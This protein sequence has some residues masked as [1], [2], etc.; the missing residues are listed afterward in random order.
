VRTLQPDLVG[1]DAEIEAIEAFLA[2]GEGDAP[3]ALV[4][5]GEAGIGKTM[6]WR[7][8]VAL[9]DALSYRVLV[10]RPTAA[11]AEMP[12]AGLN[13]LLGEA[14]SEIGQRLPSPQRHALEVA[15][16]V[17][18]PD[19]TPQLPHTIAAAVLTSLRELAGADPIL[20]AIDDAQWLDSSS[21]AALD[22][23]LRRTGEGGRVRFLLSW[24]TDAEGRSPLGADGPV[25]RVPVGPLS[26]G[27][28][29]RV[30][31]AHLG[32][33]L[34]RPVLTRV[35]VA[36]RG[37]PFFALEL[38]RV[39]E[40]RGG[41]AAALELPLP[42]SLAETLRARLDAVP[43]DTRDT[44]LTVA[45]VSTPRLELLEAVLGP[46]ANARLQP[47]IDS[48]M[49]VVD[50]GRIRFSHPLIAAA[51]YA[52]AWPERRR[53]CHL[54]LAKLVGDEDERARHLALGSQGTNAELASALEDAAHRARLRGA[55]EA[56]AALGEQAWKATPAEEPDDAWR[57]G[58]LASEYHLQSGDVVRFGE[59][60]EQLLAIARTGDER[61]LACL[62]LSLAMQETE[63]VNFWL[64]RAL[65]EAEST[66]QR[67]SVESDYVTVATVGGDLAAGT[68]H[69]RES[70]RLAEE[71]DDPAVLADAISNVARHEQLL[72]LGLRRD[73]LER[74][75]S[76]HQL[77]ET[78]RLEETVG[79]IRTTIAS[80]GLL[81]TADEFAEARARSGALQEILEQ[82]GLVQ[83]LPEVLRFRAELECWAGDWDLAGD[84]AEAGNELAEQT[85]RVATRG[86]LLF[87]RAFVAAHRGDHEVARALASEGVTAAEESSNHRNLLRH[88]SVLG[89]LD[90][91]LDDRVGAAA[92][93][94]RAAQVATAAGYVEPNWLRFHDDLTEVLIGLGRL[95][96]AAALVTWL[97]ERSLATSYPWT[98]ATTA[99][100]RGQLLMARDDLDAA[101][102]ALTEALRIGERLGNPFELAR[103][104]L[105][106][107]R[108]YRRSRQRTQAG[109]ALDE[110]LLR[111]EQLGAKLWAETTRREL[112]RISGRRVGDAD[113]LTE[114]ERRIA[115][116]VAQGRPNKEVAAALH[117]SVKT[118]EVT[119]TR[120]YRKLGVRSRG[121]LAA[122]FAGESII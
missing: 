71:L 75:D 9:A 14:L 118:V 2:D 90:L 117:L 27:A 94:E 10:A 45:A 72:G 49:L 63:A 3:S 89:F 105:D 115:E 122:R 32:H 53:A 57:R 16:L 84:L 97:E 73:L 42:A 47:A 112:G 62:M 77:R 43:T 68:R 67:Q 12:F 11:E 74:T 22:F 54:T 18:E 36:S 35:H 107:G 1:R 65:E 39:A 86:D 56:A 26:L 13:D 50:N 108:T 98:L 104:Y 44:L 31:T 102:G 28:L 85:G 119:L 110:A 21:A 38:A 121:E 111:F 78:D 19:G 30:V 61:S 69:A 103:T 52:E 4:L 113:A 66:R 5:E 6:L 95:D 93:L 79:V 59:L 60:T 70:L 83:P 37:N 58:V 81:A 120:V 64:D 40:Q 116:L 51:V 55:P 41:Q 101:G 87:P 8:G 82:Q 24:R 99:R 92:H 100:A 76:L 109:E 34:A 46:D 33:S 88:L 23:A 106:L 91:S 114:G 29:H 20:V 15:L 48:G 7:A 80:S 25:Q 96:E 17:A